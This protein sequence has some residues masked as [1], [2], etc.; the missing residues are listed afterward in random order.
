MISS[1]FDNDPFG[2]TNIKLVKDYTSRTEVSKYT[3][4]CVRQ[5]IDDAKTKTK[6]YNFDIKLK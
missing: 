5:W 3:M 6:S 2:F 4:G 1:Y